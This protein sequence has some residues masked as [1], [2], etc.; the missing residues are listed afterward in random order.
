MLSFLDRRDRPKRIKLIFNPMSGGTGA[1]ANR[2][3]AIVSAMQAARLLPEV[4]LVQPKADI[5]QAVREALGAGH[6]LFAACGGDGTIDN[7]AAALAGTRATLGILPAG[8]RNNVAYSLG[9]PEDLAA[10]VALLGSG[11]RQGIDMGLAESGSRQ[12]LFLE[13]CSVGLLSALFPVADDVQHGNLARLPD[14]VGTLINTPQADMRLWLND[15]PPVTVKGY[16][17]VAANM[18]FVGPRYNISPDCSLEDGR[19][20]LVV[21]PELSKLDLLGSALQIVTTGGPQDPRVQRHLVKQVVIET[22][23]PMPVVVDGF[24]FETSG[25]LR[26]SG[27]RRAL[28]VIVGRE[29]PSAKPASVSPAAAQPAA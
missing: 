24:P 14:V 3:E 13:A 28:N 25:P 27:R 22:N 26:L 17:L 15:D 6:R 12:R 20:E 4:Y 10:A 9:I 1:A 11:E 2:L 21:F 7:V 8:T 23:P 29:R 16:V 18:P 19:I 5:G